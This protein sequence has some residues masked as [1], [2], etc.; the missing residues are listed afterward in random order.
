MKVSLKEASIQVSRDYRN[1]DEAFV[2]L[3]IQK[4]GC[5]CLADDTCPSF[6]RVEH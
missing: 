1:A 4:L 6:E 5:S 3:T 2:D